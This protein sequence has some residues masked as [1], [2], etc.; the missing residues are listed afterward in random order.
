MA[1]APLGESSGNG[2]AVPPDDAQQL[3]QE[4]ERTRESLGATVEQLAA[5][6]DVKSRA[7]AKATELT[8]QLT[9]QAKSATAQARGKAAQAVGKGTSTAR[10]HP[11]PLSAGAAGALAVLALVIWL[12]RGQRRK[13]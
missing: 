2:S 11:V 4:I 5:K 9:S 12:L 13:R 6:I 7:R 10:K 1:G 8:G 3:H